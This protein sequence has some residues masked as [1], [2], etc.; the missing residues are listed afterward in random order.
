MTDDT[1]A[2]GDSTAELQKWK[3]TAARAQ[4]DLQNAKVRME[5]EAGELRKY[6][7]EQLIRRLLPALDN[8]QRAFQHIPAD[9]QDNEWVKGVTAI[10][11]DLFKQLSEAG[12]TRMRP[13][14]E[15]ADPARHEVLTIGP[16]EEGKVIEVLEEGYALHDRVLRPAKVKVGDGTR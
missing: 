2:S 6:A 12:V 7:S 9:L 11:Q 1:Q 15:I 4:A 16:G 13:F 10:E 14:G 3:D 5:R 8:F